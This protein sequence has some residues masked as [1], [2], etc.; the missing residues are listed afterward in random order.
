MIKKII[1][2]ALAAAML[3]GTAVSVSAEEK[4]NKLYCLSDNTWREGHDFEIYAE[5][6]IELENYKTGAEY[7]YVD[8]TDLYV[9]EQDGKECTRLTNGNIGTLSTEDGVWGAFND[10][11]YWRNRD[12][13][14]I[15]FD[16]K[17]TYWVS[18][19]DVWSIAWKNVSIDTMEVSVGE[20]LDNMRTLPKVQAHQP[21]DEEI[22]AAQDN[23]CSIYTTVE[24][25]AVKAR[26]VKIATKR[27]DRQQTFTETAIFGYLE[28][29]VKEDSVIE[30]VEEEAPELIKEV[31]AP[32]FNEYGAY[33]L[34]LGEVKRVTS[35]D[36]TEYRSKI[37]G[38]SEYE[39]WMS[40]DGYSFAEIG[41]AIARDRI[42]IGDVSLSY[43]L[44]Q[45]PY[46]RYVKIVGKTDDGKD[47]FNVRSIRVN[48]TKGTQQTRIDKDA[49]YSY[50]NIQPYQTNID[51]MAADPDE[52]ILMDGDTEKYITT[53]EKW[54]TV[55]V[56]LGAQYQIGDVDIYS[57]ASGGHFLE[58]AEIRYS[59]D[60]KKWFT[61]TYYVNTNEKTG[62]IVK[63]SFS[64]Q[65][66][67]NARYIKIIMQS[68]EHLISISEIAVN[69]YYVEEPRKPE[70]P[71]VPLRVE[72]KNYM[73]AY[74]DWSTFNEDN[75]SKFHVYI[76]KTPFV[77]TKQLAPKLV[78]ERYHDEF[79][80]KYAKYQPLE[81][82]TI[83]YFAV[84]AFDDM[85]IENTKVEPIMIK[86]EKVLGDEVGEIFN[87][88]H[89]PTM[90]KNP[91]GSYDANYRAEVFRLYD[92]LG[93][94]NKT[95][96]WSLS[97][98]DE[99]AEIGVSCN[100]LGYLSGAVD[101]GSYLFGYGNESDLA[102][103]PAANFVA[104]QINTYTRY[105]AED[106][107]TVISL[108]RMGGVDDKSMN[109]LRQV[110][111]Y[112]P[113]AVKEHS[114][115][116]DVHL[117]PKSGYEQIPGLPESAPEQM[118]WM[119]ERVRNVLREY[120]DADK[121]II[122]SEA[123]YNT[124]DAPGIQGVTY[125][126]EVGM[127]LPRLYML[128]I[129]EG[130][131]ES[132]WYAFWDEGVDATNGEHMFAMVNYFGVPKAHYYSMNNIF[133]QLR[134]SDYLGAVSGLSHP[135]YGFNFYDETKGKIISSAWAADGNEKTLTFETLSGE[136]ELIEIITHD[137]GFKTVQTKNGE[138]S[139]LIGGG[140]VYIYSKAG[141]KATQTA[142]AFNIVDFAK[143]A[144]KGQ[145][146][147][148]TISRDSLGHNVAGYITA[149]LPAGWTMVGDS[150]FSATQE[151][152]EVKVIVSNTSK[153]GSQDITFRVNMEDGRVENINASADVQPYMSVEFVPEPVTF[154]DWTKW[155]I[156][157]T[158][159]NTATIPISGRLVKSSSSGI[160]ISTQEAQ[161]IET[162]KP[163]ES[164]TVYFD[165]EALPQIGENAVAT[166]MLD[167]NGERRIIE[168]PLVFTACV[169]DGITPV[170]D[171]KKSEGEYDNC[172]VIHLDS[173]DKAD[174][175][176]DVYRKWDDKNFYML[177]DVLDDV[178]YNPYSG[179]EI[180]GADGLQFC[181]DFKRKEGI[182]AASTLEYFELGLAAE[183]S[184]MKP[185]TWAWFADMVIKQQT[186]M[187]GYE[188]VI[189][190][191][192]ETKHTVYEIAIPW[193]YLKELGTINDHKIIGFDICANDGDGEG[194][195]RA[196]KE[197]RG[198]I[199][200]SK[201]SNRFEDMVLIK[202]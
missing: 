17:D 62:G 121:P 193:T 163:G 159:K 142:R 158:C 119:V 27:K 166:F 123:G 15:L 161:N 148:F 14:Y 110:Y 109:W 112:D 56:D 115:V 60:N 181:L 192:D 104:G 144:S 73:L 160:V 108:A 61:Y 182:G 151:N 91:F 50:W 127:Y 4:E 176:Y 93:V 153:E 68:K 66:G 59:L 53:A 165:V 63:S 199:A 98:T 33:T 89:H 138:G 175:S 55:V 190:R 43:K 64:G 174:L 18:K 36:L 40:A 22:A 187:S 130:V 114:H 154:G 30:F 26:Y 84:T 11:E 45:K 128:M 184:T 197:Y 168:R 191:D 141:I 94:S 10:G 38:L 3:T 24:F 12:Y 71:K 150:A 20:S 164:R 100:Q 146:V 124:S 103:M 113:V 6:G 75:A 122:C 54:A 29:P 118:H 135:Y 169:N 117:Y 81:P 134:Y 9:L 52:K 83:Y 186:T 155:R 149:S 39:V 76:E 157:A 35:I 200:G 133:Y 69:G 189:T 44:Q 143:V 82:E 25:D 99:F 137:G 37:S 201:D 178:F 145:E 92:E 19:A 106:P 105:Q 8:E 132:W 88:T 5:K 28:K 162:I 46:G 87:I 16:L 42:T 1:F 47:G 170:I 77:N 51:I 126:K 57:L 129:S 120:N 90:S 172:Q 177:V 34:D 185:L 202:K 2:L 21:T 102:A 86:T 173:S 136:D 95:S 58:G 23:R 179:Q 196:H 167:V 198:G 101:K 125:Q 195:G 48:G 67:R 194:T 139:V 131:R 111:E 107:R 78:F 49:T 65:P 85:G 41:T 32:E 97:G 183:Q 156:A 72:M 31:N 188:C 74:L 96:G 116:I 13:V 147:A 7:S 79:K 180:W 140:P 70:T 80:N 171:G 152:I